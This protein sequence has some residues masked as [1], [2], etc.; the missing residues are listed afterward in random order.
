[1]AEALRISRGQHDT[2]GN[3]PG[4]SGA[5]S[6]ESTKTPECGTCDATPK[7]TDGFQ[8]MPLDDAVL[9]SV[10]AEI[11]RICEERFKRKEDEGQL[12]A[13]QAVPV[14]LDQVEAIARETASS[15]LAQQLDQRLQSRAPE[16]VSKADVA[17]TLEERAADS[18]SSPYP[19]PSAGA[20]T[21]ARAKLEVR[22]CKVL[23]GLSPF[24]FFF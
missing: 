23:L 17:E 11:L 8:A 16:P 12:P 13:S 9:S 24:A 15:I 18:N 3:K 19:Q 22:I 7:K 2:S 10:A 14:T 5:S 6:V 20:Q 4:F 21:S 1:M